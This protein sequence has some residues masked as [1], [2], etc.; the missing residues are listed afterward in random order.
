MYLHK[1]SVRVM[2]IAVVAVLALSI[3][4]PM[5]TYARS[6]GDQGAAIGLGVLGGVLLG[7]GKTT[8]GLLALAGAALVYGQSQNDRDRHY[9]RDRYYGGSGFY[10]N[11]YF[12]GNNRGR[13]WNRDRDH[14]R[15]WDRGRGHNDNHGRWGH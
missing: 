12:S 11:A 1:P 14:D 7:S 5:A 13:D 8:P 4:A 2:M 3:M 6:R 9:D 15:S 10:G